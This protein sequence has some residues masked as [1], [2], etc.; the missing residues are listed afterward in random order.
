MFGVVGIYVNI[1]R[2]LSILGKRLIRTISKVEGN[3]QV[4]DRSNVGGDI[5]LKSDVFKHLL[6][7]FVY[8]TGFW[9]TCSCS[10]TLPMQSRIYRPTMTET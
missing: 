8:I 10:T 1:A 4:V 5:H 7:F 2:I 3:A 6:N 9:S